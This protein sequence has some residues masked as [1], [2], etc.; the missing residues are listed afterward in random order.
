MMQGYVIDDNW[1]T[2]GISNAKINQKYKI[3]C[4]WDKLL[5]N[6]KI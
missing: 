5:K 2:I 1:W 4:F 3:K 6:L